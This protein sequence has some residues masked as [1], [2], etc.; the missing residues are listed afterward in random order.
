[1][2]WHK[3]KFAL[4]FFLHNLRFVKQILNIWGIDPATRVSYASDNVRAKIWGWSL[5]SVVA[6]VAPSLK[7]IDLPLRRKW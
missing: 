7:D 5:T 2:Q 3:Q 4:F 6:S 1:M